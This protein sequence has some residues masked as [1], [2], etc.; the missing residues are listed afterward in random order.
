MNADYSVR[1][2]VINGPTEEDMSQYA[3]QARRLVLEA[4]PEIVRGLIKKA[5]SGGYQQAKLLLELCDLANADVSTVNEQRRQQLCD[6]LLEGLG[7][8]PD[9]PDDEVAKG[10]PQETSE[11]TK[12][13]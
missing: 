11:N 3:E 13:L 4:W 8:S 7:L 6:A 10:S 9:K 1:N 5:A 2:A 12:T